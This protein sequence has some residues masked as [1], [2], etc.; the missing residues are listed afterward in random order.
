MNNFDEHSDSTTRKAILVLSAS[1][2]LAGHSVHEVVKADWA[3]D[4]ARSIAEKFDNVGFTVDPTDV[5]GTLEALQQTLQARSWDGV[6]VGW[7]TRGHVEFTVLFEQIVG[8]IVK[9]AVLQPH[10]KIM[11]STG[12]DNLVETT[13]RNFPI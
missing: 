7:C 9:Q 6:L 11:F 1:Q 5:P 8:M 4:K 3:K 10:L 12:P 13:I 2:Y